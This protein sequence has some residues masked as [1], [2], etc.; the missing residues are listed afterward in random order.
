MARTGSTNRDLRALAEAGAP[1][2][3]AILADAQD[4][5]RGRLG[6]SFASPPGSGLY[7]SVLLRPALR[8]ADLPLVALA[9]AV[10][11]AEVCPPGTRLKWPNDLVTA[12]GQKLGGLLCEVDTRG[13]QLAWVIVGVGLNV[14][15]V[16][17]ELP[18]AAC[19]HELDPGVDRAELAVRVWRS[20]RAWVPLAARPEQVIAAW[21]SFALLDRPV[22]V[23]GEV[24]WMRD[25]DADG[26]L[27][28]RPDGGAERRVLAGDVELIR[29]G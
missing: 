16:P 7:L 23:A 19:L 12:E 2:G 6:R 5:G 22:R 17:D 8:L 18:G 29:E 20:L 3:T 1:D 13:G 10:A 9:A 4:A 27:L 14:S 21:R 24:G 28:F 15:A 26:A 25:V 11:C